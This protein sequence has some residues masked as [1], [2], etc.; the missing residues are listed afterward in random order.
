MLT[1]GRDWLTTE[2]LNNTKRIDSVY[3]MSHFQNGLQKTLKLTILPTLVFTK[4]DDGRDIPARLS[5][6]VPF[7]TRRL[8]NANIPSRFLLACYLFSEAASLMED[9]QDSIIG[10]SSGCLVQ[11]EAGRNSSASIIMG[12]PESRFANGSRS[13]SIRACCRSVYEISIFFNQVSLPSGLMYTPHNY[14]EPFHLIIS[15]VIIFS[16]P[17][18]STSVAKHTKFEQLFVTY[19]VL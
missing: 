19:N 16:R 3:Q 8:G 5:V 17:G 6:G 14:P 9:P 12:K 4:K 11:P 13:I 18:T 1:P 7:W 10:L 2:M 15:F